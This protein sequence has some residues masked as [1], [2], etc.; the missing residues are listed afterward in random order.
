MKYLTKALGILYLYC[1]K[2]GTIASEINYGV[3][4]GD[5]CAEKQKKEGGAA[6]KKDIMDK[7]K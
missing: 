4:Y 6:T 1:S 5:V 3:L 7:V 2:F